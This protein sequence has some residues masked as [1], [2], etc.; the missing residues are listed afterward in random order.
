MDD[1]K[2]IVR[3]NIEHFERLLAAETS[4]KKRELITRLLAEQA[5][6]LSEIERQVRETVAGQL[7]EQEAD[8]LRE[9]KRKRTD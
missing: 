3:L 9:M 2:F 8:L 4:P 1:A 6:K 5:A 7:G